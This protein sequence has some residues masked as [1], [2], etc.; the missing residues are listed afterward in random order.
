MTGRKGFEKNNKVL[1]INSNRINDKAT[2][3]DNIK[4]MVF[5]SGIKGSKSS[6]KS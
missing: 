3:D 4:R 6:F 2:I 1:E 5:I